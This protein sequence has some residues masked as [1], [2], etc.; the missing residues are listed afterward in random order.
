MARASIDYMNAIRNSK[1]ASGGTNYG[2]LP[3][4]ADCYVPDRDLDLWER[5]DLAIDSAWSD[6]R[7]AAG[8]MW[9]AI[10]AKFGLEQGE[11][12]DDDQSIPF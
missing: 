11:D 4:K 6:H 10:F 8:A 7:I 1:P 2:R 5:T 3:T 12:H 9:D